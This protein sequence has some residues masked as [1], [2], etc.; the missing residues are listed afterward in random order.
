MRFKNSAALG[1]TTNTEN[2]GITVI[3]SQSDNMI[4]IK[5]ELQE[6]T[7]KSVLLF[8]LLG[9]KVVDWKI[10]TQNQ[11]YIQLQVSDLSTGTYIVKVLTDGGDITEK[12]LV[13]K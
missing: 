6:V 13:K 7:V 11:A 5:N 8:N 10:D 4:N 1:T 12:I 3:H 9:Q 2:H